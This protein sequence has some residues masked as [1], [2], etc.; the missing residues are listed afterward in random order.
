MSDA[1][2]SGKP[3]RYD[4]DSKSCL[5][6]V[7]TWAKI[8]GLLVVVAVAWSAFKAWRG[9][10]D[11]PRTLTAKRFEVVDEKGVVRAELGLTELAGGGVSLALC[12]ENGKVRAGMGVSDMGPACLTLA[13]QRETPRIQMTVAAGIT[14][15]QLLSGRMVPLSETLAGGKGN[16]QEVWEAA[17]KAFEAVEVRAI[18]VMDDETDR[19]SIALLDEKGEFIW[20][21]P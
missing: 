4:I 1:G 5:S 15:V 11:E 19:A 21:A 20:S 12:D 16:D 14:S 8:V 9:T 6:E 18:L 13:D 17:E 10:S 3:K 7:V 2:E